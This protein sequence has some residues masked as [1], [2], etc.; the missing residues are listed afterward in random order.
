MS[1]FRNKDRPHVRIEA[2]AEKKRL[3]LTSFDGFAA[4][5][6]YTS[7]QAV[8][9]LVAYA[10][11][12]VFAGL[13]ASMPPGEVKIGKKGQEIRLQVGGQKHSLAIAAAEIDVLYGKKVARLVSMDGPEAK[14]ML[15]AVRFTACDSDVAKAS[16]AT[17]T[18]AL[19]IMEAPARDGRPA[20]LMVD[21]RAF[22][23]TMGIIQRT[24]ATDGAKNTRLDFT[25][26]TVDDMGKILAS[27]GGETVLKIGKVNEGKYYLEF[28]SDDVHVVLTASA[29]A[30]NA[31]LPI[32]KFDQ[33]RKSIVAAE[34]KTVVEM[35]KDEILRVIAAAK[36]YGSSALY[37]ET[38]GGKVR[39]CTDPTEA[40]SCHGVLEVVSATGQDEWRWLN[41]QMLEIS[42][43]VLAEQAQIYMAKDAPS[44]MV[45]SGSTLTLIAPYAGTRY[46]K[47]DLDKLDQEGVRVQPSLEQADFETAPADVEVEAQTAESMVP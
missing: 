38:M 12:E 17:T 9:D 44:V 4:A 1:K 28:R 34:K 18:V 27:L 35:K 15:Q 29:V 43:D 31:R 3:V 46:T 6:T 36:C 14:R 16:P 11:L 13:V 23:G 8:N 7:C 41:P 42:L 45:K 22:N 47:P 26:R 37:L 20:Q 2:Q 39:Y 25:A 10:S 24:L 19:S 33:V 30:D 5:E 21:S 40:G 32:D